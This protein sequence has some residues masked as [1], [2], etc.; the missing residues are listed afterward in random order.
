MIT[1]HWDRS[2]PPDLI[3]AAATDDA[4]DDDYDDD[5]SLVAPITKVMAPSCVTSVLLTAF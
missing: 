5:R 3:L 2:R 1:H 4:D